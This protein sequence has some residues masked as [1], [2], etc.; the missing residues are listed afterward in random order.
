MAATWSHRYAGTEQVTVGRGAVATLPAQC[1]QRGLRRL[2]VVTGRSLHERTPVI[3]RV[4]ELLGERRAT[5]YAGMREHTP[6][7]AVDEIVA[8]LREHDVDGV[9][10]VGGG[11]PIDG[12]KAALYHLDGGET[13]Q[14][15][16]PTTLSAAEYT[17]TAGVT[18]DTTRRK[19]GVA[20]SRLTPRAVILDADLTVHTPQRLWLSTGIRSLDHATEAVYA[21]EHDRFA[22]ELALRAIAMLRAALPACHS[23][24]SD[25]AAREDA[26]VGAWYAGMGLA[27][28]SMGPS[29]ALGRALGAAFGIGHGIT[30]CVLLPA[31]VDWMAEHDPDAVRPLCDAFAVQRPQDVGSAI[32]AFVAALG[33][34]TTLRN[35][36]LDEATLDEFVSMIPPE[37]AGIARAAF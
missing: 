30:S 4:E 21:P 35:A 27:A 16:I 34:P 24:A 18:D 29:H 33:L 28:V 12:T 25:I 6:A 1:D 13:P 3:Q 26:Q 22:T 19:G 23:D 8:L 10:A 37:W 15:A 14:I 17:P 2:A 11:S 31:S 36:G 9:V 7:S 5:T 20:G 32:R